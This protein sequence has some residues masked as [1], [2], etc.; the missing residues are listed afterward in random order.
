MD[1]SCQQGIIDNYPHVVS[2]VL[3][4]YASILHPGCNN[5]RATSHQYR[6]HPAPV[7]AQG[8]GF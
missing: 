5:S 2:W 3:T 8:D 6:G 7:V 4:L 1:D